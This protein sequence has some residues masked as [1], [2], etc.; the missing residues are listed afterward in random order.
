MR[1]KHNIVFTDH[2]QRE[3]REVRMEEKLDLI[4]ETVESNGGFTKRMMSDGVGNERI[5][6]VFQSVMTQ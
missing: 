4:L 6:F 1:G 3:W 5:L 2:H